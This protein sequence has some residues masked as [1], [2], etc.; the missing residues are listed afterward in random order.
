LPT[1]SHKISECLSGFN[2]ECFFG[3]VWLAAT[4]SMNKKAVIIIVVIMNLLNIHSETVN[5]TTIVIPVY[6]DT[7]FK[8][9]I[10]STLRS[11]P[12][13]SETHEDKSYDVGVPLKKCT[14]VKAQT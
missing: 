13:A 8:G 1:A 10:D 7:K 12:R 2:F 4:K 5:S 14:V 3:A 11:S 9:I 6:L